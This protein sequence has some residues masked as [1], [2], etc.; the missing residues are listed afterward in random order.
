MLQCRALQVTVINAPIFAGRWNLALPEAHMS[1]R[2][3][4]I[5]VMED[6]GIG[7]D[8][9][10]VADASATHEPAKDAASNGQAQPSTHHSAELSHIPGMHHVQARGV[11]I[12]THAG[13]QDATLDGEV[14]GQTPMYMH[15]AHEQLQVIVAR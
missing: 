12:T 7:H 14:R 8:D 2:L 15:I 6:I 10:W 4:D 5:V 13:P 3:L 1:D 11:T 9:R